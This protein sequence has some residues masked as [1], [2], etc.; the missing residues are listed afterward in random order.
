MSIYGIIGTAII[1]DYTPHTGTKKMFDKKILQRFDWLWYIICYFECANRFNMVLLYDWGCVIIVFS[2]CKF[3]K[4]KVKHFKM[5]LK[6]YFNSI[7]IFCMISPSLKITRINFAVCASF[8]FFHLKDEKRML[9]LIHQ[10][11]YIM[12]KKK[13][14]PVQTWIL[15]IFY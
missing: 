2:W 10:L 5:S 4:F 14:N 7:F 12:L 11:C 3:T 15:R 1:I 8:V 6:D 9:F 13:K